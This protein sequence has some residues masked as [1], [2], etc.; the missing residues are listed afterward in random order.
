VPEPVIVVIFTI[1]SPV[2]ELYDVIDPSILLVESY[3]I[4]TL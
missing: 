1:S 2:E 4:T 3:A